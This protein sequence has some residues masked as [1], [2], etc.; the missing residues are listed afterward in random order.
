MAS[1]GL[2]TVMRFLV[3]VAISIASGSASAG[4]DPSDGALRLARAMKFESALQMQLLAPSGSGAAPSSEKAA[5]VRRESTGTIDPAVA[6]AFRRALTPSEIE[7]LTTFYES[8]SGKKYTD[9]AI[10]AIA[11]QLGI[12]DAGTMPEYSADDEKAIA[13]FV[14]SEA[15]RKVTSGDAAQAMAQAIFTQSAK[16]SHVCGKL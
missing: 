6:D 2:E 9:K 4:S 7:H 12:P 3:A 15:G 8:S 5:C 16:I 10:V 1:D 13:E 11:Q 14:Q